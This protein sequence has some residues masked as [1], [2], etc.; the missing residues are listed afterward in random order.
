MTDLLPKQASEQA[1]DQQ[2]LLAGHASAALRD[3]L[4]PCSIFLHVVDA[5]AHATVCWHHFSG[6]VQAFAP[7]PQDIFGAHSV[8]Q[9]ILFRA[10]AES[11]KCAVLWACVQLA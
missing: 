11:Q 10:S 9:T 7:R 8:S 6:A 3:E 4:W 1:C 2:Q 5:G